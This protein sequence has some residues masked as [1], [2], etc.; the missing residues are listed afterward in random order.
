[1]SY[2][3]RKKQLHADGAPRCKAA[4]L[5]PSHKA[6]TEYR[7]V[8][9]DI[10]I[11]CTRAQSYLTDRRQNK[12][13]HVVLVYVWCV[14]AMN[15]RF[16]IPQRGAQ[17]ERY[18]ISS[19]YGSL[20]FRGVSP[21]V[22]PLLARAIFLLRPQLRCCSIAEL[23]TA[24]PVLSTQLLLQI[25]QPSADNTHTHT[26]NPLI[27][28]NIITPGVHSNIHGVYNLPEERI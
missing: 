28:Q 13:A 10:V 8:K 11:C 24:Y 4:L 5:V 26:Q 22:S 25:T 7:A 1:M 27:C 9:R 3:K 14:S 2:S 18:F 20:L 19:V 12:Y 16:H 6:H 17:R 21:R 23:R 15:P